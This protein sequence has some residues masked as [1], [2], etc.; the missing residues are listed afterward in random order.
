MDHCIEQS[1]DLVIVLILSSG[2][3]VQTFDNVF[4]VTLFGAKGGTALTL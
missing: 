2:H 1:K 4:S 3:I